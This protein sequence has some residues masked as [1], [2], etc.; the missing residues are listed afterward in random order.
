VAKVVVIGGGFAGTYVA[1]HLE[2]D[3]DVTLIDC[4]EYF[5]F[6]PSVLRTIVE[7]AHI[8]KIQALHSHYLHKTHIVR[9]HADDIINNAVVVGKKKYPFDYLV[10]SSGS[11]Y[12]VPIKGDTV[13]QATR[14]AELRNHAQKL[15]K[16]KKVLIIGGG[17]VGVEL[18]AEIASHF[19]D[20]EVT[21]AHSR[22]ELMN[23]SP[24]KA[25]DYAQRYLEKRGVRILWNTYV[26]GKKGSAYLTKSGEKIRAGLAFL[27]TGITPNWEFLKRHYSKSLTDRHQIKVNSYLQIKGHKNVFAA[28]DITAI[29]EEKLAQ[30]AEKQAAIVT[31]NIRLAH[32][33]K[34]LLTYESASRPMVISLGKYDGLLIKKNWVIKGWIPAIMKSLVEWKSMRH[35]R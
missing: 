29:K 19:P 35:Y 9:G 10:V 28:G 15:K 17:I 5:E 4:K 33:K 18:A 12:N 2:N 11:R 21:L 27:C 32:A 1:R 20:K 24:K 26:M 34:P 23:R 8:K 13:V 31:A 14:A 25:R 30:T 7:P 22:D 3:F 6:T 16:T